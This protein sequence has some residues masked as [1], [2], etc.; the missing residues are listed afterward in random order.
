[1][2]GGIHRNAQSKA[3]RRIRYADNRAGDQESWTIAESDGLAMAEQLEIKCS[4]GKELSSNWA[5]Y[6]VIEVEPCSTCIENAEE[7]AFEKGEK[8]G[9]QNGI[10]E[11]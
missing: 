2:F 6:G 7:V 11:E 4:C 5:N 3:Q 8:Q 1:M 10:N 9:Y